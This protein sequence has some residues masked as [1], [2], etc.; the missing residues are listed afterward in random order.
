MLPVKSTDDPRRR[1][2]GILHAMRPF[3]SH[4][5]HATGGGGS[6]HL[7]LLALSSIKV[8]CGCSAHAEED[9]DHTASAPLLQ[10]PPHLGMMSPM[11]TGL[12]SMADPREWQ[13]FRW[14]LVWRRARSS[15]A[16]RANM[17]ASAG[18]SGTNGWSRVAAV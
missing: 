14:P 6:A 11:P 15:V 12:W 17:M 18:G 13:Y 3:L 2:E 1:P 8:F 5:C 16:R 9:G 10:L 7:Q 4:A